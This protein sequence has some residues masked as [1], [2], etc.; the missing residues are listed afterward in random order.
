[1]FGYGLNQAARLAGNIILTRLLLPEAFGLM[2]IVQTVI[3]G[4]TMV[5]DLGIE[6]R[7]I[8]RR[9]PSMLTTSGSHNAVRLEEKSAT[10][11]PRW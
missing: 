9:R 7:F 11:C 6:Q 10:N 4:V 8:C 5:S 1:M 3:T 2:V